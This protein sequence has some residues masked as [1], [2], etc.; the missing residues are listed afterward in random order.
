MVADVRIVTELPPDIDRLQVAAASEGHDLV[1]RLVEEWLDGSNRFDLPGELLAEVRCDGSLCAIGG[2]NIDPYI[3]DPGVG[4]IRHVFVD[5]AHR[6]EG[7]GKLLI[8]FLVDHAREHFERVRLRT[9]REPGPPFY[10]ALGFAVANEPDA[11]HEVILE[12]HTA[13]E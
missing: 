9:V 4:R 2:L 5:P 12:R 1:S 10:A 8:G 7:V 6:R 3:N 13:A 11:T